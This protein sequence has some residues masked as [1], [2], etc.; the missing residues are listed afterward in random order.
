[1]FERF[2]KEARAVVQDAVLVGQERRSPTVDTR[3][4]LVALAEA[5]GAAATALRDGGLDPA[6]V[7]A[8]ARR[9]ITAG[10]PL[11]A[12]ALAAVGVDLDEVRRRTDHVFGAGALERAAH[13]RGRRGKHVPFADDARKALELSLRE[14]IRLKDRSIDGTHLLLGVLR[15]GGPGRRVLDDALR[16]AGTD[17]AAVR[18]AAERTHRAA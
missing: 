8:R 14:A 3:H 12:D 2:T 6:D 9:D 15:A 7:A 13:R 4:V 16:E 5:S 1:M 17:L 10:E 11:D 18:T